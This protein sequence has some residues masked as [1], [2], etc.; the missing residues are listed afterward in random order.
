M[1][2]NLGPRCRPAVP[3]EATPLS[4]EH[5][6]LR[7]SE[8]LGLDVRFE[9]DRTHSQCRLVNDTGDALVIGLPE[10]G[11]LDLDVVDVDSQHRGLLLEL[12][13]TNVCHEPN[14]D[15]MLQGARRVRY[16]V[17]AD[18]ARNWSMQPVEGVRTVAEVVRSATDPV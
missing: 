13:E 16:V 9:R 17:L 15:L 8:A 11:D 10:A 3:L 12:N 14:F 7:I 18:Q 1:I 2:P 6:E 4:Y 5:L